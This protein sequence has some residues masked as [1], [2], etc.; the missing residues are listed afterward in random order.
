MAARCLPA[1]AGK[2]DRVPAGGGSGAHYGV[3]ES[4]EYGCGWMAARCFPARAGKHDRVPAGGGRWRPCVATCARMR[5]CWGVR[6]AGCVCVS[7]G[8]HC[9]ARWEVVYVSW[10]VKCGPVSGDGGAFRSRVHVH[11]KAMWHWSGGGRCE[12]ALGALGAMVVV[13]VGRRR[14]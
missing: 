12:H 6:A 5:T 1:R 4:F 3:V 11:K 8:G 14:V 9:L 13:L 10:G 2:H 7:W